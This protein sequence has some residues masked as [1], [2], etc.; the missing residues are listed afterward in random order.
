M[1]KFRWLEI[2]SIK[3]GFVNFQ[4]KLYEVCSICEVKHERD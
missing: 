2:G 3:K 4:A 1:A